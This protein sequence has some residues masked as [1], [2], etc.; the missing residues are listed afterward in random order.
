M[1]ISPP[2]K[3]SSRIVYLVMDFVAKVLAPAFGSCKSSAIVS[4][5]VGCRGTG[6]ELL[7]VLGGLECKAF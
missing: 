6:A 3:S 5:Y 1:V 4:W 2:E 7:G